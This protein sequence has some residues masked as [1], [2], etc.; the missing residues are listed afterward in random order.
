M[1]LSATTNLTLGSGVP[2][3]SSSGNMNL[4]LK[5]GVGRS[6]A[7]MNMNIANLKHSRGCSSCGK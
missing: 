6:S 7:Q 1:N 2:Q 4:S 3:P 5:G